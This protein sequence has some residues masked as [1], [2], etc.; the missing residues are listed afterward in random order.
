MHEGFTKSVFTSLFASIVL[1]SPPL[2]CCRIELSWNCVNREGLKRATF[3]CTF[4]SIGIHTLDKV[5]FSNDFR[6]IS[7]PFD[8]P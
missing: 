6:K 8:P 7:P 4:E 1:V 3:H 5:L 2:I